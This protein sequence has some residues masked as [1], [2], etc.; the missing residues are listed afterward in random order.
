[1]GMRA[2]AVKPLVFQTETLPEVEGLLL[3][4]TDATEPLKTLLE[5]RRIPYVLVDAGPTQTGVEVNYEAGGAIVGA[6]LLGLGHRSLAFIG[7]PMSSP[8]RRAAMLRGLR[9]AHS[10][11]SLPS[12]RVLDGAVSEIR[13]GLRQ[14]LAAAA[15]PTAVICSDDLL[16]LATLQECALLGI[17]VPGQLSVVGCGDLPF[18]RHASPALSTLRIPGAKIGAA[19]VNQLLARLTGNST[20]ARPLPIKLVIRHSSGPVPV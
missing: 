3:V 6:Y 16:A 9:T 18:A 7:S 2:A 11:P 10:V 1:M 17:A 4:G 15:P 14:W 13:A 5:A 12:L 20:T 8:W 19:A